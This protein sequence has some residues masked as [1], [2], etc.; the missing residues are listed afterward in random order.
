[1]AGINAPPS[2]ASSLT[3]LVT[4]PPETENV[5]TTSS[6]REVTAPAAQRPPATFFVDP[7]QLSAAEKQSYLQRTDELLPLEVEVDD[8]I[9][10]VIGEYSADNELFYFARYQGGLAHKARLFPRVT[11]LS[12][13]TNA[14]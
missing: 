12:M 8:S 2:T 3:P 11:R 9:D 5:T 14:L 7:P 6:S 13:S 4:P 1:M 10:E